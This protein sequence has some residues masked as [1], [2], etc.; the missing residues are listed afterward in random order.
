MAGRRLGRRFGWLWSA[1]A[2]SSLGT[3][4]AFNA[5]N[6]I[7]IK[8]LRSGPVEVAMLAAAGP[9]VAALAAVPLG[10]WIEVRRKRPVMVAMDL[11]R[12][13]ALLTIPVA[14]AF[15]ALTFAQLLAVSVVVG[16]CDIAFG[17]A[18]GAYV[19]SIVAREDLMVAS[20]RFE[21]TT[22]ASIV[23]GPPLGG[24]AVATLGPV[25]TVVADAVSYVLSA[26]GIRAI[27]GEEARPEAA[28]KAAAD[29]PT[30]STTPTAPNPPNPPTAAPKA[31]LLDGWRHILGNPALRPLYFTNVV[32]NSLIMATEPLLA[33]LMLGRLGFPPW[34][35][36]LAFAIPCVGGLIG[37]RLSA[38]LVARFGRQR[39]L[40]VSGTLRV[41][42]PIGLVCLGPGLAGL[43]LVI[44]V[45]AVLI[46]S[47][48][49]YAP[50]VA[51]LRLEQTAST[52][53][54]RV[55]AAW[56]VT[57][58]AGIA[59]GT[60]AWGLL[61]AATSPRFGLGLAGTLLLLTPAVLL[62]AGARARFAN[63][64]PEFQP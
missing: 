26:L 56:S 23:L 11:V 34:Q 43:L 13:A 6:V 33:V 35:Y 24:L 21:S 59:L 38:P 9:A 52:H 40:T 55:L 36:G 57:T 5:F 8:V 22:W 63:P 27:G 15:G 46:T 50:V 4:L 31:G 17:A 64:G 41:L 60:A 37:S 51:T 62:G 28:E 42:P 48:A 10:P 20:G 1:Y 14:Y 19:K 39:V 30:A 25:V 53:V 3:W 16:A 47:S 58:K 61:A 54:A 44:A 29:A 45:E 49:V 18:S 12:F 2:V 32:V 7:L